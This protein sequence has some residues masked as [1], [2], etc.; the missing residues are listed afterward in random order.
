MGKHCD[1]SGS[2]ATEKQPDFLGDHQWPGQGWGAEGSGDGHRGS[3][4]A[5]PREPCGP[6]SDPSSLTRA[7]TE[8]RPEEPQQ[9][10]LEESTWGQVGQEEGLAESGAAFPGEDR[11]E[12]PGQTPHFLR[13][14]CPGGVRRGGRGQR[15]S[16]PPSWSPGFIPQATGRSQQ[17]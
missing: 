5:A 2:R 15:Q 17:G 9:A 8:Q 11:Q 13:P 3:S 16:R 6:A 10:G 7:L 4:Q 12:A 1:Q 14:A